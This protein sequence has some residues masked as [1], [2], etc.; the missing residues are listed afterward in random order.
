MFGLPS[1]A[2]RRGRRPGE[3]VLGVEAVLIVHLALLGIA[4]DVVGFL[5]VL[6]SLLGGLIAGIQIRMIFARKLPVGLADVVRR[7]LPRVTP[8]VS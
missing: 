7:G 8:S 6:E 4:Q 5:D 2:A 3:A 1:A